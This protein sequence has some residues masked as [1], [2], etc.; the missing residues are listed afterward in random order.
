MLIF[1]CPYCGIT[2]D[3]TELVAGGTAHIKREAPGSSDEAF[4]QYLFLRDN[5]KGVHFE[6][7]RHTYGC[8]KWFLAARNTVTLEV[9][10]TYKAQV[11]EPPREVIEKIS[12]RRPKWQAPT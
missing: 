5:V 9:F 7:W 3:E 8:G 11:S 6:R 12:A 2:A 10:A 4:E 1:T